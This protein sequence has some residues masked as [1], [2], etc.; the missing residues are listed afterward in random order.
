MFFR[1]SSTERLN[2]D[3]NLL[4]HPWQDHPFFKRKGSFYSTGPVSYDI[5]TPRI[6]YSRNTQYPGGQ[7]D[8]AFWQGR[9]DNTAYSLGAKIQYGPIE[10]AYRPEFG[11]ITNRVYDTYPSPPFFQYPEALSEYAQGL[12]RI[13]QPQRFGEDNFPWYHHGQSY[14]KVRYFGASAGISTENMWTGPALYNPLT[15]SNNA[16][17]FFHA[18]LETDGPVDTPIGGLEA[19]IFWGGLQESDFFDNDPTNDLRFINGLIF[20]YTPSFFPEFSIG[21]SRTFY[22]YY[23]DDGLSFSNL[24]RVFQGFTEDRFS[25]EQEIQLVNESSPRTVTADEVI[26]MFTFFGRWMVPNHGFE[27][28]FEWGKNE[29]SNDKR[30]IFTERVQTRSYVIGFLK[31][32]DINDRHWATFDVEFTQLENLEN[33]TSLD[34]PVWYESLLVNQGFTHQGQVLGAGI[35]PGSNSQKLNLSYYNKWGKLGA[36]INRV[37]NNNDRLYRHVDHIRRNQKKILRDHW[38]HDIPQYPN[39]YDLFDTEY[40]FGM[41]L[42]AFLPYNF[43]IQADIHASYY[44]NHYNIVNNDSRNTHTAIT[45]RYQFD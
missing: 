12:A 26:H 28:W 34:Y 5:F 9:G 38:D 44:L 16:P 30:N 43:E 17:G 45:L 10:V 4:P 39:L 29:N 21:F 41:H 14:A 11:Y 3:A 37:V 33:P 7:N 23:P 24:T 27:A 42:L 8:G 22:E 1:T 25:R 31:R 32:I 19:K 36:S 13:D 6:T 35:G 2:L 18:F 15:L 20:S 40:R